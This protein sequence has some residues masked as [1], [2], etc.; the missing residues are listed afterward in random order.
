[1]SQVTEP[2]TQIRPSGL[3]LKEEN[4][5]TQVC[6]PQATH[7]PPWQIRGAAHRQ[8]MPE[9]PERRDRVYQDC[10]LLRGG[11]KGVGRP[12]WNW[13]YTVGAFGVFTRS[14]ICHTI[15]TIP[16]HPHTLLPRIYNCQS[17]SPTFESRFFQEP[18]EG[19]L[20]RQRKVRLVG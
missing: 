4:H 5:P 19:F 14:R 18:F 16:N 10:C 6:E 8:G 1:M 7:P 2:G 9:G 3:H 11:C 17:S 15:G 12:L 13:E 20:R